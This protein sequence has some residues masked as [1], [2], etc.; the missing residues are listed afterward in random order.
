MYTNLDILIDKF[1][2]GSYIIGDN[3]KLLK[4]TNYSR[5]PQNNDAFGLICDYDPEYVWN[6]MFVKR[7]KVKPPK[8]KIFANKLQKLTEGQLD[9]LAN[10]RAFE[11]LN[12]N[13]TIERRGHNPVP[14][15]IDW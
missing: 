5:L 13:N 6:P 12:P 9:L 14:I 15:E 1:P 3:K 7:T 2:L 8:S 4:V 11:R 10:I